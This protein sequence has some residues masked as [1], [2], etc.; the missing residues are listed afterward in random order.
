MAAI[1]TPETVEQL[2]IYLK[3]NTN[4]LISFTEAKGRVDKLIGDW[5]KEEKATKKR[6]KMRFIDIDID[7]LHSDGELKNDETI[8]ADSVIDT[9]IR[10]ELPPFLNYL[11][12]SRR[13]AIFEPLGLGTYPQDQVAKLEADFTKGMQYPSWEIAPYKTLDG[14]AT[15]GW[16]AVEVEFDKSKPLHCNID[17][18]GHDNLIF[19][20]DAKNIQA[21]EIVLRKYELTKTQLLT[22]VKK[23]GF[24]ITEALRLIKENEEKSEKNIIVYK[25][26]CKYE[27]T[28]YVAWYG[29]TGSQ[30]WLREPKPL[31]MG[32]DKKTIRQTVKPEQRMSVDPE[33]G[34]PVSITVNVPTTEEVWTEEYETMYP[35][36][37]LGYDE[38][39]QQSISSHKGRCFLDG[40]KQEASTALWSILINGSVRAG[41][42]YASPAKESQSDSDPIK[43]IDT[44]LE[45]GCIYN[46]AL[47]FWHTE[48]PP[49][50]IRIAI[51]ALQTQTQVET[52]DMSAAVV[53]REDS[54]KTA[55]E[56]SVAEEQ[57]AM[58]TT[59]DVILF[60]T[61]LREVY[62][63]V[64]LIVQSQ[65]LRGYIPLLVTEQDMGGG[66]IVRVNNTEVIGLSFVL[67]SAGD[68][69]VI[70]R[71]E[72]LQRRLALW[73]IISTSPL[74]TEFF[75]DIITEAFPDD[76]TRYKTVLQQAMLQQQ[77]MAQVG[78][79][80]Q[81]QQQQQAA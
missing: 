46:R 22:Y 57:S 35:V 12:Q 49:D 33:T 63:Y 37:I 44:E 71:A 56:I 20:L 24:S 8:I 27:G 36:F 19:P 60:S 68:V 16:D 41:N 3:E 32:R 26:W 65:A 64:W 78:I 11:K 55:K 42:V 23:Y 66:K 21:C 54:R 17:H 39:E 69:D 28:V 14:A 5:D 61:W 62:N 76:A 73:P 43:K 1:E 13:I 48:Y 75:I 15:H 77:M 18:I 80:P 79:T 34:F 74:A 52:G 45:H 10:K 67:K 47:M 31:Y 2:E 51:N 70:Q 30:D 9:N 72:K 6:R 40:P 29:G 50:S 4:N 38:T 59:V 7:K 58:L 25:K 53:N 81:Q